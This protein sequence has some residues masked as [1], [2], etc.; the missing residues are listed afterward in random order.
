MSSYD[1]YINCKICNRDALFGFYYREGTSNIDCPY[2][3]YQ[4]EDYYLIDRKHEKKTGEKI[5]KVTKDRK[6][7]HRIRKRIGYGAY[8]INKL[9]G[10]GYFGGFSKPITRDDIDKFIQTINRPEIDKEKSYL[11]SFDP[12][13]KELTAVIGKIP[14]K[15][16][17]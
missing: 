10:W 16:F 13:T 5:Y 14:E 7:I 1:D 9:S 3:G 12:T 6:W 11:L 4:Y 2:C 17:L 15:H 8:C